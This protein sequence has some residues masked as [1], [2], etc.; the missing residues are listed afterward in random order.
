M[1]AYGSLCEV[2]GT[3]EADAFVNGEPAGALEIAE[4]DEEL[5]PR[6]AVLADPA[7]FGGGQ[8]G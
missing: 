7:R 6:S 8:I 4:P 2:V 3:D 5:L 1:L